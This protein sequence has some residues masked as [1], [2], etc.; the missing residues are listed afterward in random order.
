LLAIIIVYLLYPLSIEIELF[1]LIRIKKEINQA[2]EEMINKIN[3]LQNS[4]SISNHQ[5]QNVY[6]TNKPDVSQVK[7]ASQIVKSDVETKELLK[8]NVIKNLSELK[9][10]INS[11]NKDL[12]D[13]R[14]LM[15]LKV[16]E[17]L[18]NLGYTKR[19]YPLSKSINILFNYRLI[20]SNTISL[21]KEI[22]YTCNSAVHGES[23]SEKEYKFAMDVGD[24][25]ILS[26]QKA[27]KN[28]EDF[29]NVQPTEDGF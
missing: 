1:S 7:K 13:L 3:I 29:R 5:T 19:R 22:I 23:I 4:L 2:K 16:N 12:M 20:D 9:M 15:E 28:S 24:S 10:E 6:F 8:R 27:K 14:Y 17:I 25:L 21:F 26:L 11:K 18:D